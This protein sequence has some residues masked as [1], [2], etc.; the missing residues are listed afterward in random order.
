MCHHT[1]WREEFPPSSSL[2]SPSLPPLLPPSLSFYLLFEAESYLV[3]QAV[4][5]LMAIFLPQP[6]EC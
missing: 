4:P 5:E 1:P 2:L 6:S 3:I